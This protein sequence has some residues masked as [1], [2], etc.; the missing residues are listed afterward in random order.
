MRYSD[1]FKLQAFSDSSFGWAIYNG[2][3]RH[4]SNSSGSKYGSSIAAGDIIGVMLDMV[5]VPN[6]SLLHRYFH[7]ELSVLAKMEGALEWLSK[8]KN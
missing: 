4:N 6:F 5:E 3:L 7:R 1:D 8:M 2:E